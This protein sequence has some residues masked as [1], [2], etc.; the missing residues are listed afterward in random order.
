MPLIRRNKYHYWVSDYDTY[1]HNANYQTIKLLKLMY[2]MGIHLHAGVEECLDNDY[3][4]DNMYWAFYRCYELLADNLYITDN[5]YC[6]IISRFYNKHIFYFFKNLQKYYSIFGCKKG[7]YYTKLYL[8][9]QNKFM[10]NVDGC[11]YYMLFN[12]KHNAY[13][14]IMF[15]FYEY[16]D[17]FSDFI[18]D[19]IEFLDFFRITNAKIRREIYVSYKI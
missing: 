18:E 15:I 16:F 10:R 3:A 17:Y 2:D 8:E 12:Y 1:S 19:L 13:T 9:A 4:Y 5:D 7:I 14:G 6:E 11:D